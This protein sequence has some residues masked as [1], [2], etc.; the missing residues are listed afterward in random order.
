MPI[1]YDETFSPAWQGLYSSAFLP[2]DNGVVG[3]GEALYGKG[4]QLVDVAQD[5]RESRRGLWGK[6]TAAV[7][8]TLRSAKPDAVALAHA[9]LP[10]TARYRM[11]IK[12]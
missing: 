11:V 5:T 8:A 3:Q 7:Q 6:D 2:F 12:K 1:F 9:D 4:R 10:P